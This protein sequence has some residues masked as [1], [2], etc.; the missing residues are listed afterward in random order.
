MRV[1]F[2]FFYFPVHEKTRLENRKYVFDPNTALKTKQNA[3]AGDF[4]QRITRILRQQIR[5]IDV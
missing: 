3:A 1:V 2:L 4:P 5:A